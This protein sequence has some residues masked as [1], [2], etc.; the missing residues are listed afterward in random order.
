LFSPSFQPSNLRL[1]PGDIVDVNGSYVELHK[2]GATVDF[3]SNFLPQ[4]DRPNLVFRSETTKLPEPVDIDVLDLFDFTK[5]RRWLGML[6]RVK[7][8][9]MAKGPFRAPSGRVTAAISSAQGSPAISNEL[10]DLKEGAFPDGTILKSVTGICTFFFNF[11][12]A[13]RSEADIVQ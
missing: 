10:F 12:I 5:A 13:P 8:L 9:Q 3:G 1:F 6:V 4:F 7:N 11:K 2:I